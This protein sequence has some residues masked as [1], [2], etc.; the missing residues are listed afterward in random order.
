MREIKFRGKRVDNGEWV[1]GNLIEDKYIVGKVIDWSEDYFN[2]EFWWEVIP[3]SVGQFTGLYDKN[4]IEIYEDDILK[5]INQ[6]NSGTTIGKVYFEDLTWFGAKDYLDYINK[7]C[8]IEVIGNI[9][10]NKEEN[11]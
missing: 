9:H 10:D 4:C 7:F 11:I 1:Y 3:E 2:T 6:Y 5:S 8:L